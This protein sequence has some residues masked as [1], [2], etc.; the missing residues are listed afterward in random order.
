MARLLNRQMQTPSGLTFYQ[1]ETRWSPRQGSSFQGI[2]DALINHRRSQ[3]YLMQ[4]HRW[5][6]DP[7][8][9]ANEV[10][11]FNAAICERMGWKNY[12]TAPPA[13]P[14]T[15]R[16]RAISAPAQSQLSAAAEKVKKVWQGVKSLNDWIDSGDSE[17]SKELSEK[18]AAV[19]LQCPM[20][21]T[22]AAGQL[23]TKPLSEVV[24]K[25][26]ERLAGRKLSTSLDEKLGV[27]QACLCPMKLVVHIP[28]KHKLA[29]LGDETK[30]ALHASCWV[31]HE[32]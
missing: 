22:E 11:A 7:S 4:Q 3:P 27:C 9:V 32:S 25:Q 17:V 28:L 16:F 18:R 14:P 21:G 13:E 15:P 8:Q 2:V 12:I 30:K 26:F 29:H 24:Q 19:C 6:I 20:N 1:P 23:F 5:S 10:D 31:L